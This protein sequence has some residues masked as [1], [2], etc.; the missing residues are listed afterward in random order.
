MNET[1]LKEEYLSWL[2]SIKI[3]KC[4]Y[5]SAK[6]YLKEAED[7][8]KIAKKVYSRTYTSWKQA[9]MEAEKT[10]RRW[11]NYPYRLRQWAKNN[12]GKVFDMMEKSKEEELSK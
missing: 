8:Y 3:R 7:N 5:D 9:R 2:S 1:E 6:I 11:K 4:A 12:W 10:K